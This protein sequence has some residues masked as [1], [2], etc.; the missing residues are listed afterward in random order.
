MGQ[1]PSTHPPTP[2]NKGRRRSIYTFP[3]KVGP[4]HYSAPVLKWQ[5]PIFP[6]VGCNQLAAPQ[7]PFPEVLEMR[8]QS[9]QEDKRLLLAEEAMVVPK[10]E[11][12][13]K[14]IQLSRGSL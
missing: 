9:E 13:Q 14:T 2:E 11:Q 12:E 1:I 6:G 8:M 7:P 5:S 3:I 4:S 10:N